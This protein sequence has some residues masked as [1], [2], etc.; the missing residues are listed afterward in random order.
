MTGVQG[1]VKTSDGMILI[2]NPN[3]FL[4]HTEEEALHTILSQQIEEET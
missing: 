2:T 3:R 1:I 4:L